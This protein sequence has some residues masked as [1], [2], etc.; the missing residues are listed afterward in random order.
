MIAFGHFVVTLRI[1]LFLAFETVMIK[2][3]CQGF[4]LIILVEHCKHLVFLVLFTDFH[5]RT[6]VFG[7][8][9]LVH[10]ILHDVLKRVKCMTVIRK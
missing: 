4:P 1:V 10:A 8:K 5:D 6:F 3:A 9:S 2:L 7:S